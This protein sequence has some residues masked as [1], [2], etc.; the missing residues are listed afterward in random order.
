[1]KPT[2]LLAILLT[3]HVS[4]AADPLSDALQ[5]GLFEEE[6]NHNLDAAIKAYQEVVTATDAQRKLTATAVFRLGECYRKLGQTN[7]ATAQFQRV[8]RDFS[9]QEPLVKLARSYVALPQ[10]TLAGASPLCGHRP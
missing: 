6:A 8:L 9:D 4:H 7:E 3:L 10:R 5:K 1:M 2:L